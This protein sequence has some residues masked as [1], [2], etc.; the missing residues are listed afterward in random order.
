MNT[1][2]KNDTGIVTTVGNVAVIPDPAHIGSTT[3]G[4][5]GI[6]TSGEISAGSLVATETIQFGSPF[7][8]TLN[9]DGSASFVGTISGPGSGLTNLPAAN[10]TGTLPINHG[11]TGQTTASA[12]LTALSGVATTTTITAGTG[13]SGGGD[14]SANRT[15]SLSTPVSAGNG[16]TGTTTGLTI[17]NA[18]NLSSG[19]VAD[20]RLSS[21]AAL[22]NINNAFSIGQTITASANTNTP[23]LLQAASG[24]NADIFAAKLFGGGNTLRITHDGT[25]A[26]STLLNCSQFF[27]TDITGSGNAQIGGTLFA[28]AGITSGASLT[29]GTSIS[30]AS[31]SFDVG[32]DGSTLIESSLT[33]T[34]NCLFGQC[35]SSE[36]CV[37]IS[38]GYVI[39]PFLPTGDPEVPGA[40]WV[41]Q[42]TTPGIVRCS[43]F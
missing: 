27:A 42:S 37:T 34:G 7:S 38:G 24:Q 6:T 12:A 8:S 9:A 30:A 13:L 39:M 11:G 18:S 32:T 28:V 40:L 10:I 29:V 26:C 20:A 16:G 31:G 19:T 23:L 33:A 1:I 3:I 5:S 35:G 2:L 17:L 21:N 22:K 15:I 41:D 4:S 43:G 14:L 36:P 25:I